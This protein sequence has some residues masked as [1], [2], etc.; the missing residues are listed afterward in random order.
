[1]NYLREVVNGKVREHN[2]KIEELNQ[3]VDAY[4]QNALHLKKLNNTMNSQV[5]SIE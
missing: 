5:E 4:N 1:M 3:K 2:Q